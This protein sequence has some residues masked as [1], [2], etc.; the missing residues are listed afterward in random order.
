VAEGSGEC[1][2]P[3]DVVRYEQLRRQVLGGDAGGWRLGL[4]VLQHR[5][6]AAWL[7]AWDSLPAPV[8][9]ARP[10]EPARPA[11]G[12]GEQLVAALATMALSCLAARG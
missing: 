1:A 9:S 5:G 7:A 6:V 2:V 10:S 3:G 12:S 11:S 8:A 4:G